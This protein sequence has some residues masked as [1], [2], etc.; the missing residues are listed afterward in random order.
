MKYVVALFLTSVL[1]SSVKAETV[2]NSFVYNKATCV[3][4]AA[5]F[6]QNS[7]K[8]SLENLET[9][10][11]CVSHDMPQALAKQYG[12]TPFRPFVPKLQDAE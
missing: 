10:S 4:V 3:S 1:V 12:R 2:D 7:F 9:F 8:V 6:Q 11:Q 5:E